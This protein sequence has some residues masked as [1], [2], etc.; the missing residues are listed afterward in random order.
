MKEAAHKD[1]VPD[2][3]WMPLLDDLEELV[4]AHPRESN[5]GDD[6]VEV[7]RCDPL[8]RELRGSHAFGGVSCSLSHF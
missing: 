4:A 2:K 5:V 7:M 8:K 3:V 1:N 6:T